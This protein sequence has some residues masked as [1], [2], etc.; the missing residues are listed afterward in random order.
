MTTF[1]LKS[2]VRNAPKIDH[3][4]KDKIVFDAQQRLN[5]QPQPHGKC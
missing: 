5:S 1:E 4:Y 3:L 2:C